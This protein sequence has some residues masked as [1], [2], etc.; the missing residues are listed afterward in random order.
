MKTY[1]YKEWEGLN[2]FFIFEILDT[3]QGA[4]LVK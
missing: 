1:V 3:S 4:L 2:L